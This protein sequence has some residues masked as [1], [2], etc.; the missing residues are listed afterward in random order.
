M[1]ERKGW[2]K[3]AKILGGGPVT[4][5]LLSSFSNVL[6][7]RIFFNFLIFIFLIEV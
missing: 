1:H 7:T 2:N 4:V 5:F 3:S 6:I